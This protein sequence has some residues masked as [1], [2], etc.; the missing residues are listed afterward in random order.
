MVKI[1]LWISLLSVFVQDLRERKVSVL[2]LASV[3]LC[4]TFLHLIQGTPALVLRSTLVN[5][6]L[7]LLIA[8]ALYVYCKW[9]LKKTMKESMG[10]GDLFFVAALAVGFPTH[11]FVV[12]L[13]GSLLFSWILFMLT[14]KTDPDPSVPLAG[15]QS[16][17]LFLILCLDTCFDI[18]HLY[19]L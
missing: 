5:F 4:L 3:F 15:M 13:S 2:L 19:P 1:I 18:V 17:F 12:L 7:I 9:V 14:K 6:G 8:M 16:L 10:L 11:G